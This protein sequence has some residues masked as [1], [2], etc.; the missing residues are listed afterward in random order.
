MRSD[1]FYAGDEVVVRL[2]LEILATLH[3]DGTL[4]G[5]PFMPEML[6]WCGKPFRVLRR[7]EK[8]CVEVEP[9][10]DTNRRF[11]KN[12]VVILDGPRC[13]GEG[14]D[15]CRRGCRIIWKEA[16]LRPA[17]GAD[18]PLPVDDSALGELRGRLK[19]KVDEDRYFC[20]STQL[21]QA[22]AA[23]HGRM[24]VWMT[25]I[26]FRHIR[27]GDRSAFEIAK[28]FV[29]YLALRLHR[30]LHGDDAVRGP[31]RK[32]TPVGVLDL[33]PGE[34]VRVKPMDQVV[35]T[36]DARRRNRGLIVCNEMTRCCGKTAEVRYRVERIIEEKSGRMRE[37][38]HAV[39]LKNMQDEPALCDECLCHGELGDCP[40]GELMYW[41]EIWLER[42]GETK[43]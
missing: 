14:H 23:F 11:A 43:P 1:K 36:L 34:L 42:V 39:T 29:R 20:Q 41:R 7:V 8:V 26:A 28:L 38:N 32:G 33:Q 35:G 22:T 19:V 3:A 13:D 16:W 4:D 12:D 18:A 9:P 24:K 17:Q 37:L 15:G 25:R 31:H 40:R 27:N 30:A 2:P 5:H 10:T 21:E 6:D